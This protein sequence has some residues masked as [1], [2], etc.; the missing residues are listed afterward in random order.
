MFL[1]FF[2]LAVGLHYYFVIAVHHLS[3]IAHCFLHSRIFFS[4]THD[5]STY[6]S[7]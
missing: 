6:A 3:C 2:L 1:L 4:I 5:I 7:A